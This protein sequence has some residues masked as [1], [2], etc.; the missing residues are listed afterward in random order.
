M[1]AIDPEIAG[2]LAA[3]R[4]EWRRHPPL[5]TLS[6]PEARAV[7]ELVRVRWRSG[8]PAMAETRDLTVETSAGSL[9]LR[10]YRPAGLPDG[11]APTLLY[12]HGGGFVFFSLDTHDRLMREYAAAGGFLVVGVDYPLA[13][14]HRYPLAL[15]RIVALV[16]LLGTHLG[17]DPERLAVG[18][19]SAGANLA[20]A[21]CLRLR[22]AGASMPRAI[23]SNYGGFSG[24]VSDEAEAAHGGPG[25]VLTQDEMR[26][27]FDQYLTDSAQYDDPY[28]CPMAAGD[29]TGLSPMLL[30]VPALDVLTEQSIAIA[31]RMPGTTVSIYPGATHS[32][33]EAMSISAVARAAIAEGAAWVRQQLTGDDR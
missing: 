14:E 12:L 1:T 11:P 33:L 10:I 15:N 18:G 7:A 16:R 6:P 31:A 27:F 29:L 3:L 5:D 20:L 24:N 28:A 21:T 2:F 19:D 30:I 4:E 26:W 13:P 8:G 32:F 23:L 25:A 9:G 22:D 17:I